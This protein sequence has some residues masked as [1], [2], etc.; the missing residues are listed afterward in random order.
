MIPQNQLFKQGRADA[1]TEREWARNFLNSFEDPAYAHPK[2]GKLKYLSEIER[3]LRTESEVLEV[4]LEDLESHFSG[5]KFRAFLQNIRNNVF[6][7][8]RLFTAAAED[9]DVHVVRDMSVRESVEAEAMEQQLENFRLGG[10]PENDA[11]G[12]GDIGRLGEAGEGELSGQLF[13]N[14]FRVAIVPGP[15]AKVKIQN[16]RDLKAEDIGALVTVKGTVVKVT[17]VK[18][19]M[20]LG[21]YRCTVCSTLAFKTVSGKEFMPPVHCEGPCKAKKA[22]GN[23]VPH[24]QSSKFVSYQEM[25]I[26]ETS[27]QAPIGAVPRS[28]S[29]HLS[30]S[31]V[32]SCTP[33][34]T[35]IVDGMFLPQIME[36][37]NHRDPLIHETYIEALKVTKEKQSEKDRTPPSKA[38]IARFEAIAAQDDCLG[39]LIAGLAPEIFG[40]EHVKRALLL[41]MIGGST[42][43][44]E[45][46]L[47][48]RG[49]LNV[50]LIGDPGVAKSQLLKQ[51]THLSPRGVYTTGKGSSGAGLTAS[52]VRDPISNE[53]TLEGGALVLAD[54]G[55]CCIDE[56]DKMQDSDRVAIHEVMEQQTISLAKAGI[57]TSLNARSSILAAANPV[58]G[59]YDRNKSPHDNIGLPY[60]LLSRFDLIYILLDKVNENDDLRMAKHITT[61]HQRS[62]IVRPVNLEITPEFLQ[63]YVAYARTFEP[64]LPESVHEFV[65]KRYM[66][67]RKTNKE[68]GKFG[69]YITPRSLLALIRFA[70]AAAKLRLSHEVSQVDIE[71]ILDLMQHAQNSV[72]TEEEESK[73]RVTGRV[74]HTDTDQIKQIIRESFAGTGNSWID[75]TALNRSVNLRGFS[76]DQLSKFLAEYTALNFYQLSDDG[77]RLYLV[78]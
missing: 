68:L 66:S 4:H 24:F 39:K 42:I 2:F 23:I 48:I 12:N 75:M 70:I 9:M 35:V 15:N 46:G 60:S 51:I 62:G 8:V 29:V 65:I 78:Q 5:A 25:R 61:L 58:Y 76:R 31:C 37:Y 32:R 34:D 59:R 3:T 74:R 27:D 20:V 36:G 47:R 54:L 43:S 72:L 53:I 21:A 1:R 49:D 57:T 6:R 77:T 28:F 10:Q 64:R 13:R 63:N 67:L 44:T 22:V 45:D 52:V 71:T 7:Y 30:R 40:L 55:I 38:E 50:A 41:Q 19:R 16:L 17:E 14:R 56:F 33:G 26:Q 73:K 18:P 69:Q 11:A